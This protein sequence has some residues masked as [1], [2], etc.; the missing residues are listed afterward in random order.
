M[1]VFDVLREKLEE[2]PIADIQQGSDYLIQGNAITKRRVIEI[3]N[4]VEQEFAPKT[5]ADRI[6]S[7]S[8]EELAKFLSCTEKNLE[9]RIGLTRGIL[10][11]LEQEVVDD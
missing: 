7:M 2:E 11:W 10:D 4:Q 1:S 3:F 5:N 9:I 6:R 8:D